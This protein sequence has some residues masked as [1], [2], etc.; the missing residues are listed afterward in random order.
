MVAGDRHCPDSSGSRALARS[1]SAFDSSGNCSRLHNSTTVL[2]K[3]SLERLDG[4]ENAR[5]KKQ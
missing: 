2:M 3:A 4:G 5:R 1:A